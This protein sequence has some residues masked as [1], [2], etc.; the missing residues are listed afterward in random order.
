[1]TSTEF[2][3]IEDILFALIQSLTHHHDLDVE[4]LG[5]LVAST[6]YLRD[7]N[8]DRERAELLSDFAIR[9]LETLGA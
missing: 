3:V 8:G 1:M 4:K 6:A 7:R 9:A 5:K 2:R